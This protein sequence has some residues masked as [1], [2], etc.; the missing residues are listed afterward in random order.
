MLEV[1]NKIT[2]AN[3]TGKDGCTP[4]HPRHTGLTVAVELAGDF[5]RVPVCPVQRLRFAGVC[6]VFVTQGTLNKEFF[7]NGSGEKFDSHHADTLDPAGA[8]EQRTWELRHSHGLGLR[9][10]GLQSWACLSG[11]FRRRNV[12]QDCLEFLPPTSCWELQ[13]CSSWSSPQ[14][15]SPRP[16]MQPFDAA[17]T[18]ST[19]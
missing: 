16:I 2:S 9:Q 19:S 10:P 13:R 1:R 6:C 15:R 7:S 4:H 17:V 11:S 12:S 5:A 14:G 18:G 3:W 8:Q